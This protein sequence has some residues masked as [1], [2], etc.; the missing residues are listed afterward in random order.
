MKTVWRKSMLAMT[1][2]A[3]SALVLASG[4]GSHARGGRDDDRTDRVTEQSD[5]EASHAAE[6]AARDENRAAEERAK[7]MEDAAKDPERAAEELA[8]FE[9]DQQEE[10]QKEA[11]DAADDA[12]DAAEDAAKD[13]A[14]AAEEIAE[15]GG[16]TGNSQG[17]GDVGNA[18]NPDRDSRGYPVR[19][20]EIVALDLSQQ[21]VSLAQAKGYRI[22]GRE[23]LATL[24][25]SLTRLTVPQGTDPEAA[26]DEVSRIE[27]G[28]TV[29]YTH[30]YGMQ[31][32]PSGGV[33]GRARLAPSH[34][35]GDFT[36]GMIDT[37]ISRH[38]ALAGTTINS[39]DFGKGKAG[40]PTE[41][42]TAVAS[43]LVS[44]G[45]RQIV[46]ANIFRGGTGSPF[47]SAETVAVA[48]EWLV[49][50]KVPVV[51]MSLA[52]PRN[53]ILDRL[54]QRTIAKGTAI[55]AAAGNGG[56]TAPPAYPAAL[57][58]VVAV[59]AVDANFRVYRY[60][61][62]GPYLDVAS[63]G[64][65]E[66]AAEPGGGY[67]LYTGTSFATPHIAAWLASCMRNADRRSCERKM[68]AGAKDL[69][70]PG[71]DPVYGYGL[72]R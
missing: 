4:T 38:P 62:Q 35:G 56:P 10:A 15:N 46:A 24:G 26:I 18:E 72:V 6:R 39:H 59:T 16:M 29:D 19:R 53:A 23:E 60:A 55:V 5:R 50:N 28:V 45:A 58:G 1:L 20:G 68:I 37:G 64:V 41:H 49:S 30:Y 7:I 54:V 31:V 8:K 51:N 66:I 43:I 14:E 22:I 21:G 17:M 33:V 11:E 13:T 40:I 44:E 32:T 27:P 48:L 47:T 52:G 65:N 9:E 34:K 2:P 12:A 61:N 69:G 67:S 70:A 36:V 42:G 3:L 71:R 57:P 63:L 25:G